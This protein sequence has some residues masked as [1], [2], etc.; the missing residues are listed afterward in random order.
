L[1][2]IEGTRIKGIRETELRNA[3]I[4]ELQIWYRDREYLY[5][6]DV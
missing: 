5:Q 6:E 4:K 3:G 2:R 1:A